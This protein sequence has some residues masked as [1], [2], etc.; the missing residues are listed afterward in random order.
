MKGL[1]PGRREIEIVALDRD[2]QASTLAILYVDVPWPAYWS[3][4][5]LLAIGLGFG[6]LCVALPLLPSRIRRDPARRARTFI[7]IFL[8][9]ALGVQ[10]VAGMVPHARGWPIVG[11]SMY[12]T[13]STPYDV[14]WNVAIEGLA[15]DGSRV[16]LRA[17]DT[18]LTH[19]GGQVVRPLAAGGARAGRAFVEAY[20][21]GH[22][23]APIAGVDV[24]V[25]RYRL[26]P[27]GPVRVAPLVMM[28]YRGEDEHEG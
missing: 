3:P 25:Y 15:R 19:V 7:S 14:V 27:A 10:V 16:P 18:G 17:E 5:F 23:R 28:H 6:A 22:P 8:T 11:F 24:R 2:L 4:P 12:T 9:I 1:A 20:N 26:A 13:K 21:A